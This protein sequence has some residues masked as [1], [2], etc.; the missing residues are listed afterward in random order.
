MNRRT[1]HLTTVLIISILAMMVF[2]NILST[3][4]D[5]SACVETSTITSLGP[6]EISSTLTRNNNWWLQTVDSNA[7]VGKY[8][9]LALD[10]D[11][12]P[13]VS[14]YHETNDELRYAFWNGTGWNVETADSNGSVGSHCSLALD[15]NDRP[16]ISYFG[17]LQLLYAFH[18][19]SNWQRAVVD[20]G[21]RVGGYTSIAMDSFDR[22]HISYFD[23]DNEDLKYA[24]WNGT[25]WENETVDGDGR[26]GEH[27]SIAV[28]S[29]DRPHISYSDWDNG[30]LK[31][32][33]W[34]GTAWRN[35]T[36]DSDG[37]QVGEYS[38]LAL[39]SSDRPH[40]SYYDYNMTNGDLK[41]A[42]WDGQEWQITTVDWAGR[43]GEYTSIALDAM[44]YPHISYCTYPDSILKYAYLDQ[45]DWQ[46]EILDVAAW[47]GHYTSIAL[48]DNDKPHMAYFDAD[49]HDLRYASVETG[50]PIADAGSDRTVD[51]GEPI[52]LNGSGSSNVLGIYG[53][54]WTFEDNGTQSLEGMNQ[55][56]TF[57]DTGIFNVIL[58][59]VDGEGNGHTDSMTVM[60]V[61][62]SDEVDDGPSPEDT[63]KDSDGDGWNDTYENE[64]GS[65]PYNPKSTPLDWDGDG[66]PNEKDAYPHDP[67]RWEKERLNI[68]VFLIYTVLGF[69]LLLVGYITYTRIKKKN[70]LK[71]ERRR[72]IYSHIQK[73]PGKHYRSILKNLNLGKGTL[74]HHLQKLEERKMIEVKQIGSHKLYYTMG[75]IV[76]KRLLTP[77]QKKLVK[78]INR[79][80]GS[81][82]TELGNELDRT[83]EAILYHMRNLLDLEI[84]RSENQGKLLQWYVK[85]PDFQV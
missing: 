3:F 73:N 51:R 16:H 28:D 74:S 56:Y 60:V 62:P 72:S 32:A 47:S 82:Y 43:V 54:V 11:N 61:I 76:K 55:N 84:V 52:E 18:D 81:T 8:S 68:L 10:S 2:S 57:N 80:P 7:G 41:Y 78:A 6:D 23:W 69:I 37:K 48:D 50:S 20:S 36:V 30:T 27:S 49:M 71:N 5:D 75:G 53:F 25:A 83:P 65:D 85:D 77:M 31:Y 46:L 42:F 26:M 64:S 39:D 21:G 44:D 63:D 15:S 4:K 66:V 24:Y 19:G 22:P 67:S 45:N 12:R 29:L 1:H 35:E 59:V 58:T 17:G 9:S 38:S 40:I 79:N 13:H 14:Y 34:N 33:S 70:I